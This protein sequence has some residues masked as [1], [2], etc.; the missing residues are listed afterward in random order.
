M[1]KTCRDSFVC[2]EK[3]DS[4]DT[5][6]AREGFVKAEKAIRSRNYDLVVL[7]EINV[8]VDYGLIGEE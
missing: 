1:P 2:R 7:N 4:F 6:L 3:P 8:A 5:E